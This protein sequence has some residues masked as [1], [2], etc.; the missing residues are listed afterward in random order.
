MS[1]ARAGDVLRGTRVHGQEKRG[2]QLHRRT[3]FT[4]NRR[5]PTLRRFRFSSTWET[6]RCHLA[7]LPHRSE[8]RR[9][10]RLLR[11]SAAVCS[12]LDPRSQREGRATTS[13][14]ADRR[15]PAALRT[16]GK[17]ESRRKKLSFSAHALLSWYSI[18]S[19]SSSYR[20]QSLMRLSVEDRN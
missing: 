8:C 7:Y 1:G 12:P 11:S 3:S 6:S 20:R 10:L 17:R 4:E 14:W 15:T 19:F 5:L 2:E 13:L 16:N 18:A 9:C